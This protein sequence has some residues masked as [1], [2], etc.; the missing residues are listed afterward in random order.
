[1]DELTEEQRAAFVQAGQ[2][3]LTNLNL[4]IRQLDDWADAFVLR[5]GM[6]VFGNDAALIALVNEKVQKAIDDTDRAT[7]ARLRTDV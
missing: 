4:A 3:R 6:A 1:M 7:V 5:G 2:V